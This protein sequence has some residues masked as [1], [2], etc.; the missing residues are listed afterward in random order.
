MVQNWI[1]DPILFF[2]CEYPVSP[3]LVIEDAS[4]FPLCSLGILVKDQLTMINL[5][6]ANLSIKFNDFLCKGIIH[7]LIEWKF[8][9]QNTGCYCKWY[10]L[11]NSVSHLHLAWKCNLAKCFLLMS[12]GSL[13]FSPQIITLSANNYRFLVPFILILIISNFISH[14][15]TSLKTIYKR[16]LSAGMCHAAKVPKDFVSVVDLNSSYIYL[17]LYLCHAWFGMFYHYP[18]SSSLVQRQWA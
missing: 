5:H 17:S 15:I 10:L 16:R 14:H 4:L 11:F 8:V 7:L 12:I 3:A 18:N 6:K 1:K 9:T 2:I 13:Q